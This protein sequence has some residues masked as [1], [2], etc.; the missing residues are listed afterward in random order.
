MCE[1]ISFGEFNKKYFFILGSITV[2]LIII[3]I[4]GV[5]PYLTPNDT[6]YIFGFESS[7]FSH[8]L[9]SYC[10][11][12]F[13]MILGGIILHII[14]T[15]KNKSAKNV[16]EEEEDAADEDKDKTFDSSN[17]ESIILKEMKKIDEIN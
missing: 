12:Y 2:R 1:F 6:I 15:Y 8:P 4:Y 7:F 16:T 17:T 5:T 13:S 9:I 14:Y 11:Q 3:F 10:F